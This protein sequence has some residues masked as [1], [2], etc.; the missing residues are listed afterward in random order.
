MELLFSMYPIEIRKASDK[1]FVR[2]LETHTYM[3]HI[4]IN[5]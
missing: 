2:L 5:P 3:K 4:I 1:K